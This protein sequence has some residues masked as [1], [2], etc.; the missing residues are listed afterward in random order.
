MPFT[1]KQ[2]TKLIGKDNFKIVSTAINSRG[3]FDGS[4][5]DVAD[6]PVVIE[7]TEDNK[8]IYRVKNFSKELHP[9]GTQL[10][11]N[12]FKVKAINDLLGVGICI[13]EFE[14]MTISNLDLDETGVIYSINREKPLVGFY[15]R[16]DDILK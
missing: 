14:T 2:L 10:S 1:T 6:L 15:S 7:V 13:G 4:L 3:K 12:D 16:P 9:A 8:G 5:N 11:K